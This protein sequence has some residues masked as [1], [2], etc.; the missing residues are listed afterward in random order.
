LKKRKIKRK[1]GWYLITSIILII[2][3]FASVNFSKGIYKIWRL[4]RI[5]H[6]EEKVLDDTIEEK[7]LLEREIERLTTDSLY[8]EEIAREEYGMIKNGEE[9]FHITLPDTVSKGKQNAR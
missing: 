5:K 4:S 2:V 1:P 9:V 6:R 7:E 3:F 8:I